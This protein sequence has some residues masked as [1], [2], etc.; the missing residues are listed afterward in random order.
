M[1]K[2]V[3]S[4]KLLTTQSASSIIVDSI[5]TKTGESFKTV[6]PTFLISSTDRPEELTNGWDSKQEFTQEND[7]VSFLNSTL[8]Q[9]GRRIIP[10]LTGPVVIASNEVRVDSGDY[11]LS[12]GLDPVLGV[13]S[14]GMGAMARAFIFNRNDGRVGIEQEFQYTHIDSIREKI[15]S[16]QFTEIQNNGQDFLVFNMHKPLCVAQYNGSDIDVNQVDYLESSFDYHTLIASKGITEDNFL[17]MCDYISLNS[18]RITEWDFEEYGMSIGTKYFP[19]YNHVTII[20]KYVDEITLVESA[21][22]VGNSFF[23]DVDAISGTIHISGNFTSGVSLGRLQ[24]FY[25][26]YGVIP[27]IFIAPADPSIMVRDILDDSAEL[28]YIAINDVD[29]YGNVVVTEPIVHISN[30]ARP[31]AE[32]TGIIVPLRYDKFF[33][34]PSSNVIIDGVLVKAG[35]KHWKDNEYTNRIEFSAP[36]HIL[37]MLEPSALVDGVIETRSPIA[38]LETVSDVAAVYGIFK[39]DDIIRASLAAAV[40]LDTTAINSLAANA[41]GYGEGA[42]GA[43]GYGQGKIDTHGSTVY[44]TTGGQQVTPENSRIGLQIKPIDIGYEIILPAWAQE[45]TIQIVEIGH[46]STRP[47]NDWKFINPDIIILDKEKVNDHT[48]YSITFEVSVYPIIQNIN[49][50]AGTITLAVIADPVAQYPEFLGYYLLHS[51]E[52][53]VRIGYIDDAGVKRY[54]PKNISINMILEKEYLERV[55]TGTKTLLL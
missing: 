7:I 14:A 35:H 1:Q 2:I 32:A 42:Y 4:A 43:G 48:I 18:V 44:Y 33:V 15:L 39:Y 19:I 40:A 22:Q 13:K 50:S 29:D 34:E 47:F 11:E 36:V 46:N 16:T 45:S 30:A 12:I 20:A 52:I 17:S 25:L 53:D 51:K 21:H 37:D 38:S 5:P 23:G 10:T 49:V 31:T 28:S 55:I 8:T 41:Q 9:E 6:T 3:Y 26:F 54:F 27:A 24:G